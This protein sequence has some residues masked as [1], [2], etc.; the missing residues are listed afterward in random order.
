MLTL[1]LIVFVLAVVVAVPAGGN[2][3]RGDQ[4]WQWRYR[5]WMPQ[6]WQNLA[7]CESGSNPPNWRHSSGTY[8][9]A[10]GFYTGTWN[11]YRYPSYPR[12]AY[13]ATPWQ[14]YRV[15]LRVA[16]AVGSIAAPWGCWRGPHHAWVRNGLPEWG[17][18][19]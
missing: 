4:S 12:R 14:Q 10:F 3:G 15:A 5:V 7:R 13:L 6:H 9:G 16:A 19:R 11:Q 2:A 8:E 17:V 18:T 1:T